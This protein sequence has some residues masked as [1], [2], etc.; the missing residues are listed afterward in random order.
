[1]ATILDVA[2]DAGVGVGTVSRVLNDH[3]RVAEATRARVMEAIDRLGYRPNPLARG[4]SLGHSSTIAVLVPSLTSASVMQ[5]LGGAIGVFNAQER[6]VTVTSIE[7]KAQFDRVLEDLTE[8]SK[9]SGVLVVSLPLSQ[10]TRSD[11]A[12]SGVALVTVDVASEG[13][14][15]FTIDDVL[16]GRIATDHLLDLGQRRVAFLGDSVDQPMGFT[17]SQ[18]REDGFRAAMAARSVPVDEDLVLRGDFG[19]ESARSLTQHLL[20]LPEPPTAVF[21]ASDT[22]ALGVIEAARSSRREVPGNLAVIGFDDIDIAPYVGLTT[23]RQRLELSGRLS[24]QRMLDLV[25]GT[26]P[27]PTNTVLELELVVRAT[28]GPPRE[29]P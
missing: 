29:A 19:L 11:L 24:A 27:E 16:G 28:T 1:M 7:S 25:D 23:V 2:R 21:A 22:Q 12:A 9:P 10:S 26:A 17:S 4:L 5:R 3:P 20:R 18:R 13:V 14:H 6:P 15:G 8:R